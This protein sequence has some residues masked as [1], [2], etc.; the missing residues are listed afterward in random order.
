MFD[1]GSKEG[2]SPSWGLVLVRITCGII[3]LYAGWTKVSGGV[4]EEIVTGTKDAFAHAPAIVRA[5]GESVVLPHPWLFSHLI[6]WGELL[7][8]IALF[9]GVLTRPAGFAL[10]FQF[11]N[12]YFAGPEQAQMFVLLLAVCC[13]G[14]AISR[15]GRKAGMDVFL[16]GRAPRWMTL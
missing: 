7:G 11:A 10:T 15:A 4:H 12:F 8:G 2:S 16:D 1:S 5:W 9:L 6:A 3:L 14:C 13:F